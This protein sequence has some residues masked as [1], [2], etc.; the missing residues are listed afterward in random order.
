[1]TSYLDDDPADAR[2]SGSRYQYRP[3]DPLPDQVRVTRIEASGLGFARGG[4]QILDDVSLEAY[5]G[6]ALAV[7]GPSGSGKSSLLAI[8]AGLERADQ[9]ELL[10]DDQPM[11]AGVPRGYALVLQGYG[12]VSV[13]TAAENVEVV[14]QGLGL[15]RRE[16][17]DRAGAVLEAVGLDDVADHLVEQL[18]GGQQQRVAVAR[19]LVVEPAVLV[20]DEFTA[21]LDADSRGHVLNLVL[22]VARRGGLVVIATHDPAVAGLCN[23]ELRLADGRVSPT[24]AADPEEPDGGRSPYAP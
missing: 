3:G 12:L 4:R 15:S 18:S 8:L 21:E 2:G 16:V 24:P 13:L 20:A 7:T 11:A 6:E 1:M 19:A 9:G 22:G 14:L 10:V 23:V 17:R 5:A